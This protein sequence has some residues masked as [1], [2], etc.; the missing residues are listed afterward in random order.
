VTNLSLSTGV[1]LTDDNIATAGKE[2]R[3]TSDI[4]F[5][6]IKKAFVIDYPHYRITDLDYLSD[7]RTL[8]VFS[9]RAGD[10]F[11][12]SM[13]WDGL[14]Q[15]GRI[16]YPG[17]MDYFSLS[18]LGS[19][20]KTIKVYPSVG[21]SLGLYLYNQNGNMITYTTTVDN[22]GIYNLSFTAVAGEAYFFSVVDTGNTAGGYMLGTIQ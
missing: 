6:K 3:Y 20:T 17:D 22:N 1:L 14:S 10:R 12:R 2:D 5:Y 8:P 11:G 19:G 4:T 16:D 7:L 21:V 9:D 18:S 13:A 15:S